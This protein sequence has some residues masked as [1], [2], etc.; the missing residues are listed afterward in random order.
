MVIHRLFVMNVFGV[1]EA[2]IRHRE[3]LL[4]Y[5]RLLQVPSRVNR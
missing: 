1:Q 5:Y 2:F 3:F 4:E